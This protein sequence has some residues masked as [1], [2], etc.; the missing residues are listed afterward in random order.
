[1]L[2]NALLALAL[3]AAPALAGVD[4]RPFDLMVGDPAPALRVAGWVKGEPIAGFEQG[5]AYV[6][7]FWA[8]WCGPCRKAI[9]HVSDLQKKHADKKLRIVGVSVWEQDPGLVEPF[10]EK[11][12]DQM[13][14]TVAKDQAAGEDKGEMARTW[15]AASGQQGIPASFIVDRSGRIA[16]IGHP[17]E[18]DEPLAKVLDGSWDL[19]KAAA[20]Y[21]QEVAAKALAVQLRKEIEGALGQGRHADALKTLEG[22]F[23]D[24]PQLER[25]FGIA[26]LMCLMHIG[27][28]EAVSAYGESLMGG[29]YAKEAGA[30][31]YIAWLM[32]D[33]EGDAPHRDVA[34]AVRA[35]KKANELTEWKQ[36][37]LLDT[38]ATALF[39]SGDKE[40]AIEIQAKAVELA[41]GTPM[42]KDL[43]ERLTRFKTGA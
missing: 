6:V 7:E 32:V 26:K 36:A 33:P 1:M 9:P 10:V 2:R 12:G 5:T 8:T 24:H 20:D 28:A 23:A 40:Q 11:M 4:E 38:Y 14:Y 42:E 27:P 30:L 16:W 29:I 35:A 37:A 43:A 22:A 19:D 25:D 31:N 21:R 41:K 34:L 18:I 3:A 15:M 39:Q 13:G 17:M